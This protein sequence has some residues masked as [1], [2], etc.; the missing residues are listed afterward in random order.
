[1]SPGGVPPTHGRGDGTRA[2]VGFESTER[3]LTFDDLVAALSDPAAYDVELLR[4]AYEFAARHHE[5][6]VRL[7]G[8]PYVQHCLAVARILAELRLDTVTLV[9]GLLHDV[10]EDTDA[11]KDDLRSA[12]GDHVTAVVDGVTKISGFEFESPAEHQAENWRKMLLAIA[13]DLRVILIKLADRLHNMRTL[14]PLRE[15]KQVR[16]ARETMEIYAPLAHRFGIAAVKWELEDLSLKYLEPKAYRE[17]VA[18]VAHRRDE[19]EA[20]LK[21]LIE[22]LRS[23]LLERGIHGEISGRAKHFYSIYNKMRTRDKSFEDIYDLMA[24]RVI[25]PHTRDCYETLGTIHALWKP[26]PER[27]KDYIASPKSNHYRSLHT[28]VIGPDHT[29]VEFQIRTPDMHAEA[30]Y[31]IAAH[32]RYKEGKTNLTDLIGSFPWLGELVKEQADQNAEEF[33]DLLR[34]DLFRGEV[35]VFTPKGEIKVL[36][37]DATPIDFAYAIHTEVGNHCVGAR[38]NGR[39]VPLRY[40]LENADTVEIITSPIGRPSQDWLNIVASAGARSKVRRYF[41]L[42]QAQHSISLGK[43][44]LEREAR[45]H[46]VKLEGAFTTQ[47]LQMLG[48]DSVERLYGMVGQ[49]DLSA[50]HVIRKVFPEAEKKREPSGLRRILTFT[51]RKEGGVRVQGLNNVMIRFAQCCQP[52][53][54]ESIIGVI[55]RGRGISVHRSDCSNAL[56]PV[57]ELERRVAVDWDV[58][59]ENVFRVHLSVEGENRRGLL[60]DVSSAITGLDTNILSGTMEADG[61]RAIGRFV[62]EVEDLA[63]LRRVIKVVEKLKGVD[64]VHRED[65]HSE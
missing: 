19:R 34:S 39:I 52:L 1:V 58:A 62:I 13:Q 32:W 23:S 16:I 41:R 31:G 64:R 6:Q 36:P 45:R 53:P 54:G 28:T 42:E 37:R 65:L 51:R 8:M 48:Y 46:G 38:V 5:G 63:H 59:R 7:S 14:E 20:F 10:V 2:P 11:T 55:T 35:F 27:I 30:E 9:A 12:F 21:R 47:A 33:L 22:P 29:W 50:H 61:H 17:L 18:K 44:M 57:V 25:V 60:A 40:R 49:G 15:D 3:P 4:R 56:P 26:V 24:I 43:E